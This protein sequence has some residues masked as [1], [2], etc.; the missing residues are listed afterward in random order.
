MRQQIREE[1]LGTT[2]A[3]FQNF[4][5]PLE[6]ALEQAQCVA[7]GGKAVEEYAKNNNWNIK[8]LI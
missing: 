6:K 3:D 2:L 8:K 4:A 1:V 5:K 7:L